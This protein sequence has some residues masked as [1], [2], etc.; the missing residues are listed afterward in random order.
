MSLMSTGPAQCLVLSIVIRGGKTMANGKVLYGG[1]VRHFLA[2]MCSHGALGRYF[3]VRFTINGEQ[4]PSPE[5]S[6]RWYNTAL[7]KGSNPLQNLD[8]QQHADSLKSKYK[9]A[10]ITIKKVTHAPRVAAAR[11]MDEHGVDTSVRV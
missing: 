1:S 5:D 2:E 8:W 11:L 10:G 4:F 3:V 6:E 9:L 7:W